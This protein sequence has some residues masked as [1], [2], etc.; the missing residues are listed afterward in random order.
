MGECIFQVLELKCIRRRPQCKLRHLRIAMSSVKLDDCL[1]SIS[2]S[3][4]LY[5]MPKIPWNL[6]ERD[7]GKEAALKSRV[8]G[9][10]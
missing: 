2:D 10:R 1:P 6:R 4:T 9:E 8:D 7:A 3:S 5:G